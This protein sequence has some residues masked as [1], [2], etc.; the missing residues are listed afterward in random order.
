[1]SRRAP[2]L[3]LLAAL[4]AACTA[5]RPSSPG[6]QPTPASDACPALA[7]VT[8]QAVACARDGAVRALQARFRAEVVA[9]DD[10]RTAEGVLVWRAPGALRVKLFTLAG[11]TVYDALWVGDGDR[12]RGIVRQPLSGGDATFDLAPGEL[13]DASDADLSLVLWSLWQPRCT[14]PPL[15]AGDAIE[16]DPAAARADQRTVRVQ[17]GRIVE[18]TLRRTRSGGRT[19]LVVAR[20]AGYDCAAAPLPRQVEIA[21]PD[22]GWRARVTIVEQV[23]DPVVDDGLFALPAGADAGR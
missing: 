4:G 1:V 18:E 22:A 6:P 3:A 19:E 5:S 17:E 23:R 14:R 8:P 9:G 7:E 12:L 16:L 15:A 11:I 2:A 10:V 21:A 13:P 20:Y